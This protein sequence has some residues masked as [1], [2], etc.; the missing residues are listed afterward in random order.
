MNG[1]LISI[2]VVGSA[3]AVAGAWFFWLVLTRPIALAQ[4]LG[5]AF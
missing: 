3:A 5:Q 1:W 2:G 4:V